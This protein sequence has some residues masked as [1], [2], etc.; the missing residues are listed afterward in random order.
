MGYA[1]PVQG[2]RIPTASTTPGTPGQYGQSPMVGALPPPPGAHAKTLPARTPTQFTP[3]GQGYMPQ[4]TFTPNP[5]MTHV[6]NFS[7]SMHAQPQMHS[8]NPHSNHNPSHTRS[9]DAAGLGLFQKGQSARELGSH[10]TPQRGHGFFSKINKSFRLGSKR[11]LMPPD[12]GNNGGG[13]QRSDM[14]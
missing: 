8:V 4:Q 11:N 1:T 7:N 5:G 6:Q 13:H 3:Q 10:S 9:S 2:N 14:L 12:H